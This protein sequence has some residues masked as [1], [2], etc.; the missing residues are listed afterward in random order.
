MQSFSRV[1]VTLA[2]VSDPGPWFVLQLGGISALSALDN[3]GQPWLAG[4]QA[5]TQGLQ[6]LAASHLGEQAYS[7]AIAQQL[8]SHIKVGPRCA[9]RV[10]AANRPTVEETPSLLSALGRTRICVLNHGVVDHARRGHLTRMFHYS[11]LCELRRL[12]AKG[13]ISRVCCRA[14]CALSRTCRCSFS[15]C[16]RTAWCGGVLAAPFVA[17]TGAHCFSS[18]GCMAASV[19]TVLRQSAHGT[20]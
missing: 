4:L 13:T 17:H 10:S 18:A 7:A 11:Y 19:T 8:D 6:D 12:H 5:T 1:I 2:C 20:S 9:S 16:C 14:R 15:R 3:L